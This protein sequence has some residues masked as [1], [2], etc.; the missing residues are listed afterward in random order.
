MLF[1]MPCAMERADRAIF[2]Y[3]VALPFFVDSPR[4]PKALAMP[5]IPYGF[6]MN[7]SHAA[8]LIFIID[9]HGYCPI[10]M[11]HHSLVKQRAGIGC[12]GRVP[13]FSRIIFVFQK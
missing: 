4:I 5:D 9:A 7:A 11:D 12:L 3:H 1:P 8:F 6:F 13:R 2:V 10:P